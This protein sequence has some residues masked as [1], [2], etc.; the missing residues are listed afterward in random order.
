MGRLELNIHVS[1][2]ANGKIGY[3]NPLG[4]CLRLH[5]YP[6]LFPRM[7]QSFDVSLHVKERS[8]TSLNAQRAQHKKDIPH[9]ALHMIDNC[10]LESTARA[11]SLGIQLVVTVLR[12]IPVKHPVRPRG[13]SLVVTDNRYSLGV[14]VC[15]CM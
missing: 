5:I 7:L 13:T 12:I 8:A 10:T 14:W 6:H 9:C 1:P 11:Q 3:K 4:S 2:K 15:V